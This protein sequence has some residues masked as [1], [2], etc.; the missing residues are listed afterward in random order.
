MPIDASPHL[1][2]YNKDY[3][4][5]DEE[6]RKKL[7]TPFNGTA[8]AE[9]VWGLLKSTFTPDWQRNFLWF[10]NEYWRDGICSDF[11]KL[12]VFVLMFLSE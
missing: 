3:G 12:S 2:E 1:A 4:H 5:L 10:C 6:D 9:R 8:I 11:T 7:I